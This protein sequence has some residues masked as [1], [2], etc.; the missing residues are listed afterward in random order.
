[1][2]SRAVRT[3]GGE[4][5]NLPEPFKGGLLVDDGAS[6]SRQFGDLEE[7]VSDGCFAVSAHL[8]EPFDGHGLGHCLGPF[9]G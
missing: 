5:E 2:S 4:R 1:M 8:G 7:R 3:C 9:V 6:L